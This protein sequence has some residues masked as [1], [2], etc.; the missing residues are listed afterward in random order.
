[1]KESRFSRLPRRVKYPVELVL[2]VTMQLRPDKTIFGRKHV[3][4]VRITG[5]GCIKKAKRATGIHLS[6]FSSI[7]F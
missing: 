7:M 6:L 5:T 4:V 2:D 1:L 3:V